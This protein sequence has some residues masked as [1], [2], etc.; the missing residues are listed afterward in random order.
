MAVGIRYRISPLSIRETTTTYSAPVASATVTVYLAG[1][2]T[3]ATCYANTTTG[4]A[5]AS[6]QTTTNSAGYFE[7]FV[8]SAD[9]ANTQK[10][11]IVISKTGYPDVTYDYL[12]IFPN[13]A[14][15]RD[16]WA[17]IRAFGATDGM[18]DA[19]T[20]IQAAVDAS[21]FVVIPPGTWNIGTKIT[22]NNKRV[23]FW[24]MP[25]ATLVVQNNNAGIYSTGA[26]AVVEI[27]GRCQ[28]NGDVSYTGY[29]IHVTQGKFRVLGTVVGY[30]TNN[31]TIYLD[32]TAAAVS[33][34]QVAQVFLTDAYGIKIEGTL[35]SVDSWWGNIKAS[36]DCR[37]EILYMKNAN[38]VIV[39]TIS[40]V[41]DAA[42]TPAIRFEASKSII[43]GNA[44]VTSAQYYGFYI[45]QNSRNIQINNGH[46][47][48]SNVA[49]FI[50]GDEIQVSNMMNLSAKT[51]SVEFGTNCSGIQIGSMVC[52]EGSSVTPSPCVTV[53]NANSRIKIDGVWINSV[54]DTYSFDLPVSNR[55]ILNNIGLLTGTTN[56]FESN[57]LP[58]RI[59]GGGDTGSIVTE[60]TGTFTGDGN[61][62]VYT[63]PHGLVG[64]TAI[65]LVAQ[66][67]AASADAAGDFYI[68]NV[69]DT[70]IVVTYA[71]ATPAGTG[72]ISLRWEARFTP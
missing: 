19:S 22:V 9:Y 64:S 21:N 18:A 52:K 61:A 34:S 15:V 38:D 20:S 6:S 5:L 48:N 53:A 72:N 13:L 3:T 60:N 17:D 4:T 66:V 55:V 16:P 67:T 29:G 37:S 59:R 65:P 47:Y 24:F 7:F 1:T 33:H 54:D 70:N 62:T 36:E 43:I 44:F 30:Q 57:V 27:L 41:S 63:I 11:K 50:D 69:T 8:D 35:S 71:S 26:S 28:I 2:V 40:G 58:Y 49:W 23:S 42:S 56:K 46:D 14:G 25:G 32:R 12:N 39:G 31:W 45:D 10:F 51:T 68:S